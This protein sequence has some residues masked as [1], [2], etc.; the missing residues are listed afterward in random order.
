M[1]REAC[2]SPDPATGTA[3]VG[4]NRRIDLP[5]PGVDT[6]AQVVRAIEALLLQEQ[7][8]LA[9]ATAVMTH[10]DEVAAPI[11]LGEV[12]RH[13][14]HRH[15]ARGVDMG[16]LPFPVLPHVED[17]GWRRRS[18]SRLEFEY[19]D[20]FHDLRDYHSKAEGTGAFR[21]AGTTVSNRLSRAYSSD[22]MRVTSNAS[23]TGA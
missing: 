4:W 13:L 14:A 1:T 5:G 10:H 20:L 9:A 18:Q 8:D 2:K 3:S 16:T 11:E 7:D 21:R 12:I 6:A 22:P 19:A 15:V 17:G 23:I